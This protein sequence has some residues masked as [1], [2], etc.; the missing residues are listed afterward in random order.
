V[1][2][3]SVPLSKLAHAEIHQSGRAHEY[4][5]VP[6]AKWGATDSLRA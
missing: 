6:A 5:W 1:T 4:V 3:G 2:R